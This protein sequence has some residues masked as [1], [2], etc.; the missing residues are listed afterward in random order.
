MKADEF[1]KFISTVD[2]LDHHQRTI[3][4]REAGAE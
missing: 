2:N 4:M 1:L 3:L